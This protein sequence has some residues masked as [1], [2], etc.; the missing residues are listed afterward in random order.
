MIALHPVNITIQCQHRK[1]AVAS[2]AFTEGKDIVSQLVFDG[3]IPVRKLRRITEGDMPGEVYNSIFKCCSVRGFLPSQSHTPAG[4]LYSVAVEPSK[5][6][7]STEMVDR[8][9]G[10]ATYRTGEKHYHVHS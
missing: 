7:G 3:D 10:R 4:W 6:G 8:Q 1:N 5:P 9:W 2:M